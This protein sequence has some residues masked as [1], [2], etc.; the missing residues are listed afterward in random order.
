M[1][2]VNIPAKSYDLT[3]LATVKAELGITDRASDTVL[4][5]Y[6]KQ[7]SD[8][9]A[10]FCNR[11]FALETV[12]EAFRI[13]H[14]FHEGF[15]HSP[16]PMSFELTLKR[17]PVVSIVSVTENGI[18]LT[19]DQYEVDAENGTISRI[20]GSQYS[21]WQ[22]GRVLVTYSAGFVLPGGLPRGIER[23]AI[24]LVKQ[25]AS[26]GDR[27]P[28]VRSERVDGAGTTEYFGADGTGLTPDIQ[29]L[30]QPHVK[31]NG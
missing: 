26:S 15:S 1:I 3:L 16:Y 6:I 19:S 5:S 22:I 12:T 2:T 20:C 10:E 14:D 24:Q 7:A 30:L 29:G 13:G 21:R 8:V 18:A 4:R 11:V 23:A 28:L 31:P 27:D 9:I 17:Y 25:F